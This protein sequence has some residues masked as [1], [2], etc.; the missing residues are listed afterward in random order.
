GVVQAHNQVTL[1][2]E[3]T[4]V[5]THVSPSFEV[6]AYFAEGE[7]LV[8]IDPQNYET[9]VSMAESRLLAAHSALDLAK[10]NEERKLRLIKS[11]AVSQ[12]EVDEAS[13]NREQA[14]AD[15]ELAAAQ[16]EQAKLDLRRTKV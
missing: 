12:A 4:G 9:A 11:N 6:G 13:A 16:L 8:E 3:I 5:V 10:L 14:E 7:L 2:A 15:V 1:S